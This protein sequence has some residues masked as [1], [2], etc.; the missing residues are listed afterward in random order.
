MGVHGPIADYPERLR[1]VLAAIGLPLP[2]AF[3]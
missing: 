3:P 1:A 2:P